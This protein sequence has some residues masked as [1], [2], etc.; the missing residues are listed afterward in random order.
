MASG[1]FPGALPPILRT[2]NAPLRR[3]DESLV[4][5]IGQ[6][7]FG[8]AAAASQTRRLSGPTGASAQQDV[9]A[10]TASEELTKSPSNAGDYEAPAARRNAQKKLFR[11]GKGGGRNRKNGRGE[12]GSAKKNGINP[13]VGERNKRFRRKSD[14]HLL[15]RCAPRGR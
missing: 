12:G 13:R 11:G 9:P 4:L 7:G 3:A 10:A 2:K 14:F 6:W 8:I 15:P 5:A 1:A